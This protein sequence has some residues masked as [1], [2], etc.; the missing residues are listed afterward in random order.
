MTQRSQQ[1]EV[2][3]G[4]CVCGTTRGCSV[5]IVVRNSSVVGPRRFEIILND[6][7]ISDENYSII[8]LRAMC[9]WGVGAR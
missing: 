1:N 8:L 4:V 7:S 2:L 6:H 3:L 9:Y 5:G